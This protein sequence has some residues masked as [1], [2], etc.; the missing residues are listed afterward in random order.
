MKKTGVLNSELA[1]TIAKMGHKDTLAIG[2]AGLPI[3]SDTKRIDLAV[4]LETPS[5]QV[6]LENVLTELEVESI[7]LAEEIKTANPDQ[8]AAIVKVLPDTPISFVSH[9]KLKE[10]LKNTRAVVRTGESH[11]F[12]NIIL[13]S[14]VTF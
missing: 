5:F 13:H 10:Q 7:T 12:A 3:P 4:A 11:P 8:L 9:E 6:V 14:G 2:D 1:Y